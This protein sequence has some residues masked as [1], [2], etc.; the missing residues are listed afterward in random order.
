MKLEEALEI[1][2][3]KYSG[4]R[5]KYKINDP[6]PSVLIID[7]DYNVDGNGNSILGINLNYLDKL[8][9]A[10]KKELLRDINKLDN[11][12][13]NITGIKAWL[14]SKFGRGDYDDLT[15]DER[16]KR[17]KTII[18]KFPILK[19]AIRRYKHEAIS[20]WRK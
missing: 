6:N 8:G 20:K 15:T 18:G 12:I 2:D 14:R 3:I 19:K 10:D 13:L 16:I 17:Y 11:K 5:K 4:S 9:K 1:R 7:K